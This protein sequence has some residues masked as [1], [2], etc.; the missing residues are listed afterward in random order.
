MKIV[1]MAGGK[2]TR[3]WPRSVEAK[4]KQFL[5]LTSEQET[6]LQQTYRR[7]RRF[8]PAEDVLL[9]VGKHYLP[10]VKDQLPELTDEQII[11]E[12]AQR[13]TAPCT[14]LTAYHFLRKKMDEVLVI[15]PSDQYIPDEHA[16][17]EAL[18]AGAQEAEKDGHVVTL[19]I[20]PTRPETGY[21]YIESQDQGF[22]VDGKEIKPVKSFIEK[23]DVH[24]AQQLIKN[25]NVYWNSGIFIWKPSTIEY[26]MRIHQPELWNSITKRYGQLS[27]EYALLPKISIDYAIL[28]KVDR[29]LTIPVSFI[30]DDVGAWTSLERIFQAD[31]EG[32]IVQGDIAA[33]QAFDNI[34]YVENQRAAVIGV[35]DLIVV[36]T[37]DG[38]LI[39]HKSE[40][41]SI[42][43]MIARMESMESNKGGNET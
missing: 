11:V 16:L 19:G 4:P 28:E 12:P 32:N 41:Q 18:Y 10:L 5:K 33:E 31:P 34:L 42:K 22:M 43:Q 20:V 27:E 8:L 38:L 17:M 1:I 26:Y 7:F 23:P 13:D 15:T 2:G 39:C 35:R 14:A 9:V 3:F 37:P 6:M 40:E 24:K 36:S 29:I 30:W 21:G 25:P